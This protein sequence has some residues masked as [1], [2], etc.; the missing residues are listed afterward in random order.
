MVS[1]DVRLCCVALSKPCADFAH[2]GQWRCN[3]V[4]QP[5]HAAA[6]PVCTMGERLAALAW[7]IHTVCDSPTVRLLLD[8]RVDQAINDKKEIVELGKVGP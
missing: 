8:A 2:D 6:K 4:M 1:E 7:L 5:C 3:A